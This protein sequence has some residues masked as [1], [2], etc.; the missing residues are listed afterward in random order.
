[1]Q[2]MLFLQTLNQAKSQAM[3]MP[4]FTSM[5]SAAFRVP[6]F[7]PGVGQVPRFDHQDWGRDDRRGLLRDNYRARE[8][9]RDRYV[10]GD[11]D[12]YPGV[13]RYGGRD[14]DIRGDRGGDRGDKGGDRGNRNPGNMDRYVS[15]DVERPAERAERSD[16][17][18]PGASADRYVPGDNAERL[19]DRVADRY[20][21][22]DSRDRSLR[23]RPKVDHYEP[24]SGTSVDRAKKIDHYSSGMKTKRT[25]PGDPFK[26]LF[27]D[28]YD[29]TNPKR[30]ES[31]DPRKALYVD[32]YPGS[33][34]SNGP[35]SAPART[36]KGKG[37]KRAKAVDHY[38]P[39]TTNDDR[40]KK[41]TEEEE[42]VEVEVEVEDAEEMEGEEDDR[43]VSPE[44]PN[45]EDADYDTNTTFV[46]EDPDT[47]DYQ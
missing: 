41:E 2:Q 32:H 25:L 27:V 6:G 21:P 43:E 19:S 17:Y 45:E 15:K 26:S 35:T 34:A 23:E 10:S 3:G 4:G 22:R 13:D 40:K 8:E 42:E 9:G 39:T 31:G 37:K 20:V 44:S 46:R 12:R 38:E 47:D 24:G 5:N 7:F 11:P 33:G 29:P 18:I 1:M 30:P 14:R 36:R 16:R 28:H